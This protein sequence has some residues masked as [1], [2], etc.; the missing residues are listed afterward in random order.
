MTTLIELDAPLLRSA[1]GTQNRRSAERSGTITGSPTAI[2]NADCGSNANANSPAPIASSNQ[3]LPAPLIGLIFRDVRE[4]ANI[5][6]RR[7]FNRCPDLSAGHKD[8]VSQLVDRLV[9]KLMH[10]CVAA[11]RER[12]ANVSPDGMAGEF[13]NLHLTFATEKPTDEFATI[14]PAPE[15]ELQDLPTQ[16]SLC[17]TRSCQ[18]V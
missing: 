9:G 18:P 16:Y 2:V 5:E 11:L 13:E 3:P 17:S 8:E 6:L 12:A 4:L 10:A 14:G 1:P 15:D 7:L